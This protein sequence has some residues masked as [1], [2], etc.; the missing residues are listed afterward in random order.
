MRALRC[1]HDKGKEEELGE[2]EIRVVDEELL[3]SL[4]MN[5]FLS[6]MGRLEG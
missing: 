1:V 5:S 3:W 4:K 2:K 6:K